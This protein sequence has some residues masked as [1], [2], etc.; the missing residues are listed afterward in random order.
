MKHEYSDI[1][2]DLLIIGAGMAGMS[3]A[4]F[5]AERNI[6]ALVAGGP[7]TIEYSSGLMDLWGISL[8]AKG[9]I[10]KKPWDMLA[11]LRKEMPGHPCAL[12]DM[13]TFK[14]AFYELTGILKDNGLEYIGYE[15]LNSLV[16][17][18]FGTLRPCFRLPVTMKNNCLVFKEKPKCLILGFRGLRE[19]SP[20][21][22]KE[23]LKN[24]WPGLRASYIQ[25]PGCMH[26]REL[27]TPLMAQSLETGQ[28]QERLAQAVYPVLRGEKFLGLPAVLGIN[29]SANV[30]AAL[31]NQLNLKIFEIPASP[32]SVPGIRLKQALVKALENTTITMMQGARVSGILESGKNKFKCQLSLRQNP[33]IVHAKTVLLATGRFLGR[34]LYAGRTKIHEPLFDLPVRQPDT[35]R[36]WHG[37]EFFDLKGH[38]VNRAGI[39][40]DRFLRP[41]DCGGSPAHDNLFAAG[42]I[43]AGQDF[44][45]ER[46]GTG[47]SVATAFRAVQNCIRVLN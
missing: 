42:S 4:V 15:K 43:L 36:E 47:L 38:A 29:C 19:F 12:T 25:F 45:R 33:V 1:E 17:T 34:G 16:M 35:R 46:C 24:R 14:Q 13:K 30:L 5:A 41:L 6:N 20:V 37:H 7:G 3:A 11:R 9:K 31:E 22:F 18:P 21:F 2:T 23:M 32:V 26:A 27:F 44:A 28:M 8:T 40:T 10:T 39:E